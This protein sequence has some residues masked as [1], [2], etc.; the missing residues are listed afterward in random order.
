MYGKMVTMTDVEAALMQIGGADEAVVVAIAEADAEGF[1]VAYYVAEGND[2]PGPDAIRKELRARLPPEISPMEVI[3]LE[4]LPITD[5]K[6][7]DRRPLAAE[8]RKF[9]RRST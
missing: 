5:P 9:E 2:G 6:R 1:L 8:L 4:E 3:S 7:I